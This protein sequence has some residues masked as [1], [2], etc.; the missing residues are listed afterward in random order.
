MTDS[1]VNNET[2][3]ENKLKR[4]HELN[5]MKKEIEKEM[6]QLK[7]VFHHSLD[8][9]LGEGAK[10]EITKGNFT[11]Q[12]QIRT[13]I[14]YID[15]KTVQTLEALNLKDCIIIEKKPDIE[16]LEAAIK[17]GI[18]NPEDFTHCK[19][20]KIRQAIVVKES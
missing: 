10:G 3:T 4:Y 2:I 19:E 17:L 18:I 11:L 13:S 12:R 15:E 6:K 1:I 14:N 16:K 9:E 8:A 5:H 7:Q 20:E